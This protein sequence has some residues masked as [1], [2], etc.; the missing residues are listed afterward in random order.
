MCEPA[1]IAAGIAWAGTH[2]AAISAAAAIGS[3]AL[4]IGGL[5][6]QHREQNNLA[7][8]T[9]A[10]ATRSY[11]IETGAIA[12]RQA[13]EQT[14]AAERTLGNQREY[15][16]ANATGIVG[17][18]AGG[19]RGL[20]VDALLGDLA[21]QQVARQA[22][23]EQNTSW[24]IQQLQQEKIGAGMSRDSRIASAP[25]ASN[26]ALAIKIGGAALDGYGNYSSLRGPKG[27]VK[28]TPKSTRKGT[29]GPSA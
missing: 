28:P 6:A 23:V 5:T 3:T 12:N 18:E 20:S 9:E 26:T 19:V 27:G 10:S 16:A 4:T 2:A 25:R 24:G 11:E 29:Y 7:K 8:Q 22:N 1:T 13:Q 14:A 17:A 15:A 21:G